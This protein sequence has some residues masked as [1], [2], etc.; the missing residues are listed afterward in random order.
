MTMIGGSAGGWLIGGREDAFL[1][2]IDIGVG[3][4][5]VLAAG[6]GVVGAREGVL[7]MVGG[8]ALSFEGVAIANGPPSPLRRAASLA[9]GAGVFPDKT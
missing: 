8:R 4:D 2:G 1:D 5:G 9:A 7:C 3:V 6:L